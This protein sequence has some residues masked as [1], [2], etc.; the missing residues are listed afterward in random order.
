LKNK[1][2]SIFEQ[3]DLTIEVETSRAIS[4]QIL[5]HSSHKFQEFSQRYSEIEHAYEPFKARRQ[6]HKNRQ[7]SHDDLP[8][9]IVIWWDEIQKERFK[10]AVEDYRQA[11]EFGIAKEC[12]RAILPM[13][14]QTRLYMKGNVRSWLHYLDVRTKKSTQK[15]HRDV[16]LACFEIFKKAFPVVTAAAEKT[17]M[18]E[19]VAHG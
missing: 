6:D 19:E 9:E 8:E 17:G 11:L 18:F 3:V 13:Q 15:E 10:N 14:V 12:A 7:A 2:W 16:A 1:H 4:A 5:R